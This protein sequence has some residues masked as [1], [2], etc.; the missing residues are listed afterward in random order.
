MTWDWVMNS[1]TDPVTIE[2]GSHRGP[3]F[4]AD[5]REVVNGFGSKMI[6]DWPD[7]RRELPAVPVHNLA[8]CDVSR[9]PG[10][11]A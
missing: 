8:A 6:R 10:R 2:L 4:D 11:R 5:H 9:C 7:R 3:V 1:P